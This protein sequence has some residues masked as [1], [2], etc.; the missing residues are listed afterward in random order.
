MSQKTSLAPDTFENYIGQERAVNQLCTWMARAL[1]DHEPLGHILLTS[2]PGMG[3]TTLARIIA[4][5]MRQQLWPMDLAK[6]TPKR[7]QTFITTFTGGIIFADEVHAASKA[8]QDL[9]LQ[10]LEENKYTT[11]YIEWPLPK[12]TTFIGA[13]THPE[14]LDPAFMSRA[15]IRIELDPYSEGEM[16]QMMGRMANV[17]GD[18]I[19]EDELALLAKATLG[20]PRVAR[21]VMEAYHALS[22]YSSVEGALDL[23]NLYHD[24]MTRQHLAY[25]QILKDTGGCRGQTVISSS[26]RLHPTVLNEIER[27][28]GEK[29]FLVITDGGRVI[30]S[31]GMKRLQEG[32]DE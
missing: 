27:V 31:A 10:L 1:N 17:F 2:P 22:P 26:L 11:E 15:P 6:M 8:Q 24:G 9:F 19:S 20:N 12:M 25:L 3:K 32:L 18:E 30:T 14:K 13:T 23:V 29:G 21:H 5:E 7:V 16:A 4:N 28:L